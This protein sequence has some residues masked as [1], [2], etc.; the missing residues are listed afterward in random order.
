MNNKLIGVDEEY[1]ISTP[2]INVK[3]KWFKS[4]SMDY[5]ENFF[6]WCPNT[7]YVAII[8]FLDKV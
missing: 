8:N 7:Q 1:Y 3:N 4:L 6:I 5:C 2:N